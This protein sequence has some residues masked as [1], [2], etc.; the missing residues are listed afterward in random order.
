MAL[1]VLAIVTDSIIFVCDPL[2]TPPPTMALV[3]D[4][5]PAPEFLFPLVSPKSVAFP[6]D[7]MVI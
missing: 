5:R 7:A 6:V 4:E 2:F 1:P 3:E